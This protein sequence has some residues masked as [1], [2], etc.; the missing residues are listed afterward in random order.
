[1]TMSFIGHTG[2]FYGQRVDGMPPVSADCRNGHDPSRSYAAGANLMGR[3][4]D[5]ETSFLIGDS[6]GK[7]TITL[8]HQEK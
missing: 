3:R 2:G 7:V 5:T 8:L 1:M 4:R 6:M